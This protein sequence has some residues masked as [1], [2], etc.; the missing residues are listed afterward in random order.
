MH[1]SFL[2]LVCRVGYLCI[3]YTHLYRRGATLYS[4][5][6]LFH[7]AQL[8]LVSYQVIYAQSSICQ[9]S[10]NLIDVTPCVTSR[11]YK[12]LAIKHHDH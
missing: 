5:H 10:Q 8:K 11:A 1:F 7:F 12:L 6:A 9:P 2:N 3:Y 4:R